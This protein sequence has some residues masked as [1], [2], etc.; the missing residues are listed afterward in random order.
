MKTKLGFASLILLLF[1]PAINLHAQLKVGPTNRYLQKAD[2]SSFLWLGDTAWEL[3]HKLNRKEATEYL[4]NRAEKGFTIIQ[5]VV[6]AENDGLRTPNP[7]GDVPFAD[8]DPTKPNEAYFK[9]VDFIVNKAEELGLYI[10]MLPTWGDKVFSENAGAGPVVFNQ[11]NAGIFGQYLGERYKNKPIVWVL[12]GDRNI[13]N[14]EVFNIWRSMAEGIQTGDEGRNLIT[15]HPRGTATSAFWFHNEPWLDFNMYQSGHERFNR[16]YTYAEDM[17]MLHP[18]KPFI[19]GEPAYEDIAVRFWEFMDFSKYS[20]ERVPD[21]VLDE[22]GLIADKS[23][24]KKGFITDFDVRVHAYWNFLAGACG[25][26]YGNNAIW[27]M[28]KP[29]GEIAIPALTGWREA[30][31]R[32]GAQDMSHVRALFE[33]RPFNLLIPDQSL[34]FGVN[35]ED[36]QHIRA[37]GSK[38][39]SY[40]FIY[41]AMGQDVQVVMDKFEGEEVIAWWFNPRNGKAEKIDEFKGSGIQTFSPPT[42]GKTNDWLLVIDKVVAEYDTPGHWDKL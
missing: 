32:P 18:V 5:A 16:V 31:D 36:N 15:Y 41:L 22:Q 12:G 30:M 9:H 23:H 14:M 1:L 4:Q 29:G 27:Q 20:R 17:Y 33:S 2:G 19:D 42:N 10:G 26:T 3:F 6:L 25:Y 40:A 21:G 34:V 8:L 13:A 37:G 11:E 24:F 28:Y 39:N 7:Y 35:R 38:D